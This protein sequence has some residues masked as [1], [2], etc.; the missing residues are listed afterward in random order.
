LTFGVDFSKENQSIGQTGVDGN[1]VQINLTDIDFE[2]PQAQ[3][4]NSN[5]EQ[6]PN[7]PDDGQMKLDILNEETDESKVFWSLKSETKSQEAVQAVVKPVKKWA[8]LADQKL[9]KEYDRIKN[10]LCYQVP[11]FRNQSC[12]TYFE[13]EI[14]KCL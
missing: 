4:E 13:F 7:R 11:P 3:V 9:V 6:Q 1:L 10:S 8:I 5:S 2:Y 14:H 12:S